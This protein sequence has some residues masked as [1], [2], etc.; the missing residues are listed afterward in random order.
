MKMENS[1]G[2]QKDSNPIE[3]TTNIAPDDD[4]EIRKLKT[5]EDA[6]A[7]FSRAGKNSKCRA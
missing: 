3:N 1:S 5:G 2:E 4:E 6:I 7:F